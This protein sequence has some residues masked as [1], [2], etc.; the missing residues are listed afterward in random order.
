MGRHVIPLRILGALALLLCSGLGIAQVTLATSVSKVETTLDPAG[1]VKRQ[2]TPADEVL[3]GEE[4]RYVITFTN[5]GDTL[6]D[7][8]RVIITNPIPAA[9]RY[10]P[11]SAGGADSDIEFSADGEAFAAAEP[12]SGDAF[13]PAA[14][15]AAGEDGPPGGEVTSLRWSYAADLAPGESAEVFFHVRM[16]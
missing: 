2:L 16:R 12:P 14:Q 11:G 1:R 8:G 9:A 3:P 4:L 7:A 15:S 13:A 10:V 5:V 6:V